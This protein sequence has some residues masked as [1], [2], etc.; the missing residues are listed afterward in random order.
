MDRTPHRN[1]SYLINA[2][3]KVILTF[4]SNVIPVILQAARDKI[5]STLERFYKN[6]G[7][8]HFRLEGMT[9][10]HIAK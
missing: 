5:V 9:L 2:F 1:L 3:F 7:Q 6:I 8:Y 4:D 10:S